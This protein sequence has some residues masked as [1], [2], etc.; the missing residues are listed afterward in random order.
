MGF[1]SGDSLTWARWWHPSNIRPELDEHGI[2]PDPSAAY[3]RHVNPDM[4]VLADRTEH[5]VVIMLAD[6]GM[7]KSFELAAEIR[8]LRSVGHAVQHIDL[9]GY[10]SASEVTEAVR[11]GVSDWEA[12]GY[13]NLTLAFDGFDEALFSVVNLADV[14][15]RELGRLDQNRVKV[16]IA[17]RSSLWPATLARALSDWSGDDAVTLALAPLTI[18]QIRQAVATEIDDVDAYVSAVLRSGA[19]PLAA[20][21]ITLRLLL[22]AGR[23][24]KLPSSRSDLYHLGTEA[25]ATEFGERRLERRRTGPA[26]DRLRTAARRLAATTLLAGHPSVARR[27][28]P[29]PVPGQVTLDSVI[30]HDV[31]VEDLEAVHDSALFTGSGDSRGW[32]HR[33]VEEYLCAEQLRTLPAKD[34]LALIADP[35]DP[36]R[37]LPQL[38]EVGAWLAA[39]DVDWFGWVL[40]HEPESLVNADLP[41]RDNEQRRRVG[42]ALL[43]H[44]GHGDVPDARLD[45]RGMAY[46]GLET[47]LRP[48]LDMTQPAAIRREAVL[49]AAITDLRDV[50][51][52]LLDMI[53]PVVQRHG[54]DGYDDDVQIA[55]LAVRALAGSSNQELVDRLKA[56]AVDAGVPRQLRMSL[57]ESLWPTR[58]STQELFA[59]LTGNDR[60][61][62]LPGFWR[63][64]LHLFE[65]AISAGQ[66]RPRELLPWFND[67]PWRHDAK[68][69]DLAGRAVWDAV[70]SLSHGEELW[71]EAVASTILR[72]RESAR[73]FAWTP[74]QLDRLGDDHRRAFAHDV[75]LGRRDERCVACLLDAGVIRPRDVDWWLTELVEGLTASSPAVLSAKTVLDSLAWRMDEDET[76]SAKQQAT[77]LQVPASVVDE[78]FGDA[79]VASRK[80]QMALAAEEERRRFAHR[81]EHMFSAERLHAALDADEFAAALA[82][83][84]RQTDTQGH[85]PQP[86]NA[87]PAIDENQRQRVAVA[88]ARYLRREDID[89]SDYETSSNIVQAHA[90]LASHD[91][92]A[93]ED[94]PPARWLEWLPYLLETPAAYETTMFARLHSVAFDRQRTD[95]ILIEKLRR[96]AARGRA[97]LTQQLRDYQSTALSQAALDLATAA[98]TAPGSLAGLLGIAAEACPEEAAD[99][100]L[101]H[102]RR[103][104]TLPPTLDADAESIGDR[105]APELQRR[106]VEATAA[107]AH[108]SG[109]QAA[110]PE[111][112]GA[113]QRDTS[114]AHAVIARIFGELPAVGHALTPDQLA[115][116]YLW[117]QAALPQTARAQP[118][119]VY[120][121]SPVAEFPNEVLARLTTMSD[122]AAIRAIDEIARRT[123]DVWIRRA[124]RLTRINARAAAW[125]SPAPADILAVLDAPWRRIVS[126]PEQLA[127]LVL[128]ELDSLIDNIERDRA[129]KALFW[130]R[131][132]HGGEWVGYAPPHETELSDRLA[133]E[134]SRRV[135]PRAVMLREVEIQP[136]LADSPADQPDLLATAPSAGGD[137][138]TLPIE[139]KCN[140]NSTL[141]TAIETQLGDRYLGGPHG[142]TGIYIVGYYDGEAW[143]QNDS[144]HSG[145]RRDRAGITEALNTSVQVLAGRGVTVYVRVMDLSLDPDPR[146]GG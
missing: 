126:T 21:P 91:R 78:L 122:P 10:L 44:L 42:Q 81:A 60:H 48:L 121:A 85:G 49:I 113:F 110:F 50:D 3:L 136:R 34:A 61:D 20:R 69:D 134:L 39:A 33:S 52:P 135:L 80:E 139:V 105:T 43:A 82:E 109:L 103:Y 25:L 87:W 88:A 5:R 114:F 47:D 11:Q 83:L 24:A 120:V 56:L 107:L 13:E 71:A 92:S 32:I 74:E 99:A 17:S 98:D 132:R 117:A 4:A 19:G 36:S 137:V 86:T 95:E 128:E 115:E 104:N 29:V 79:A 143:I 7:G 45:Y 111:L 16:L 106:A 15:R 140:W 138:I 2:L 35:T 66:V 6:P 55:C 59:A 93:L 64:I 127:Q 18:D 94:V 53:L 41:T 1:V 72:M 31:S 144:R 37:L 76:Q 131:Q 54:P 145:V 23:S 67:G 27:R 112:L 51:G 57:I 141:I 84:E 68:Y 77:M 102:L 30:N 26:L 58:L 142:S 28:E 96:D 133:R 108:M 70:S 90:I 62:S 146:E 116:L 123:G 125:R 130:H 129:T 75:L 97:E 38:A 89:P 46:D 14:L 9:G 12:K 100:A 22:S 124:A 65:R 101:A 8:R 63:R 119:T 40:T 118:G 73:F